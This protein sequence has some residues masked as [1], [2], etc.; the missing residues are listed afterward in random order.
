MSA[1]AIMQFKKMLQNLDVCMAKAEAYATAKKFDVNILTAYRLAPDMFHLT[2]QVHATCDAAKFTA[3]YLSGQ[4]APKHEDNET[5]FAQTR[6]R[7]Q[8]VVSYL[9]GFKA[10]DFSE[11]ESIKVSPGWA[12]GKWLHGSEYLEEVAIPNFYFH[13]MAT[14]VILR[15]AGV[16]VGKLDYL[17]AINLKE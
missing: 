7:I 5:T 3:A 12:Q 10:A 11:Y 17:G 2:K 1:L 14:Y 9:D 16:D 8:K 6:E 4:T 13:L 15:H